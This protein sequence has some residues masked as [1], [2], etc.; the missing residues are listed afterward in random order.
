[1][2][3]GSP[4]DIRKNWDTVRSRL[5]S[6]LLIVTLELGH[7]EDTEPLDSCL[8]RFRL[9]SRYLNGNLSE[10]QLVDLAAQLLEANLCAELVDFAEKAKPRSIVQLGAALTW[11]PDIPVWA[12]LARCLLDRLAAGITETGNRKV[13][14]TL[15]FD[16]NT[17]CDLQRRIEGALKAE[18]DRFRRLLRRNPRD[19]VLE[20]VTTNAHAAEATVVQVVEEWCSHLADEMLASLVAMSTDITM[21]ALTERI[22]QR[23]IEELDEFRRVHVEREELLKKQRQVACREMVAQQDDLRTSRSVI[24]R[25]LCHWWKGWRLRT[26]AH[27]FLHVR[28]KELMTR[29]ERQALEAL[30]DTATKTAGR[31]AA[32]RREAEARKYSLAKVLR[33]TNPA[34]LALQDLQSLKD[35]VE[36][37]AD[38]WLHRY[39]TPGVIKL[40]KRAAVGILR[41]ANVSPWQYVAREAENLSKSLETTPR[42]LKAVCRLLLPRFREGTLPF[43]LARH[44]RPWGE[45]QT[46]V[47][48]NETCRILASD[49][50]SPRAVVCL[51]W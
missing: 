43:L 46:G 42:S 51:R 45:K 20:E 4:G 11:L 30:G 31:M 47:P 28:H 33:P 17:L 2:I 19:T 41:P 13:K 5:A 32:F 22:L 37:L 14:H 1:V 3:V 48:C 21:F 7:D 15:L 9:M 40:W 38:A 25:V 50:D 44:A 39:G 23:T 6:D 26:L 8:G 18:T 36:G 27:E 24:L 16:P 10:S 49:D 35:L 29:Y 34:S 12:A